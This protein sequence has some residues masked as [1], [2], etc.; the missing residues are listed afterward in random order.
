MFGRA[1]LVTIILSSATLCEVQIAPAAGSEITAPLQPLLEALGR[2]EVS[3]SLELSGRCD[4]GPLP[5]FPHLGAASARG[6]SPLHVVREMFADDPA[7]Q[8][9]QGP[10]GIIRMTEGNA[11]N[12]LLHVVIG[13]ISFETNGLP[14]QD[15]AFTPNSALRHAILKSPEVAAFMK[16]HEIVLAYGQGGTG[17]NALYPISSPHI[18]GSMDNLTVSAALDRVLKAFPGVWVYESCPALDG[19]GQ[20]IFLGFI[21]FQDPGLVE[22]Q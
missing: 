19:K 14:R 20:S 5:H 17:G 7:M 10:D 3:G 21:K 4:A 2:S 12:E 18:A 16:T 8:I 9:V 15:A 22:H 6:G 1:F 13:H 11:Q